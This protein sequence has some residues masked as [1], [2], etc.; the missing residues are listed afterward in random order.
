M[1]C[2]RS[3]NRNPVPREFLVTPAWP[4]GHPMPQCAHERQRVPS[5]DQTRE[6]DKPPLRRITGAGMIDPEVEDFEPEEPRGFLQTLLRRVGPGIITGASD[7]DPSGIGTY[8]VAGAQ[9][10]Y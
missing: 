2:R 7:D 5:H 9:F 10:G 8:A 4:R 1:Q 3:S 6:V